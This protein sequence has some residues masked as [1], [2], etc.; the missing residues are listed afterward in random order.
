[1]PISGCGTWK[2]LDTKNV[3]GYHGQSAKIKRRLQLLGYPFHRFLFC[4]GKHATTSAHVRML[5]DVQSARATF[6][7]SLFPKKSTCSLFL[8][9]QAAGSLEVIR[10]ACWAREDAQPRQL[11]TMCQSLIT[12]CA[13]T[14][15]TLTSSTLYLSPSTPKSPI[16]HPLLPNH[17]TLLTIPTPRLLG[18]LI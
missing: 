2:Q 17:S 18:F 8:D 16:S 13:F 6:F 10:C 11:A 15:R 7:P 1:M 9:G 5:S 12:V 14:R 4:A 3:T